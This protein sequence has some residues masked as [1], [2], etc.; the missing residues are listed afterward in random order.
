[1]ENEILKNFEKFQ[2]KA[3]RLG[4]PKGCRI[5]RHDKKKKA[6]AH[7]LNSGWQ[8]HCDHKQL[9]YV[10]SGF[11]PVALPDT[12][13]HQLRISFHQRWQA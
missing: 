4:I 7:A 1:L 10:E 11:Y 9:F 8:Q 13:E 6:M 2:F 3:I 12:F 5:N